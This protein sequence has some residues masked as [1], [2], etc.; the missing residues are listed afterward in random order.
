[1]QP[2]PLAQPSHADELASPPYW[3]VFAL[4]WPGDG[5]LAEAAV[6]VAPATIPREAVSAD[7][8]QVLGSADLY[9]TKHATRLVLFSD[10]TRMFATAGTSLAALGV[11]WQA[12]LRELQDDP[13]L[14]MLLT[15]TER[16]HLLISDPG[17]CSDYERE[18]LRQAISGKLTEDWP[19]YIQGLIQSGR[20]ISITDA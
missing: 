2:K 20:L 1:M 15:I 16:A 11:D 9:A 5:S 19:A 7:A 4:D 10:L 8:Q 18:L 17:S 12:A 6:A 14:S 3:L 13:H